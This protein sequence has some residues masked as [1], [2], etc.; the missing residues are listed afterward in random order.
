MT[1]GVVHVAEGPLKAFVRD[2]FVNAGMGGGAADTVAD[3][4]VWANLRGVDSHGVLRMPRYLRFIE[5]GWLNLEPNIRLE[6][7]TVATFLMDAD[8]AAGAIAM[9]QAMELAI[10]KARHAGIGW[11]LVKGMTH[12]GAIGYYTLMASRADMVGLSFVGS[13]PNMAYHGARA[14]GISTA[15]L[16]ISVPGGSHAPLMLDMATAMISV[17]RLAQAKDA[18]QPIPEGSALTAA[19]EPTTDAAEASLPLPLGGPKGAGLSLMMECLTGVLAGAPILTPFV[20]GTEKGHRQNGVVIAVDISAFCD[21]ADYGREIERL[22]GTIKS[23]P[24]AEGV[25]ELLVP[26]ERG[27]RVLEQRSREGIALN[28]SDWARLREAAERFG[29]DMPETL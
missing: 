20:S 17:G 8:Q 2:V 18:G 21:P 27:D 15:P 5:M 10:T 9:T 13:I 6:R 11:G 16:A 7:E 24:K 26:G 22:I 12:A 25:D 4:L 28:A 3:V 29:L 1:D 23:L 19:G 14:A